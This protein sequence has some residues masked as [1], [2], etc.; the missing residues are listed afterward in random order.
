MKK[1]K[2]G[3]VGASGYSGMELVRL[4]IHHP[5]V[6]LSAVCGLEEIGQRLDEIFPYFHGKSELI[7]I[8]VEDAL[9]QE[10]DVIFFATPDGVAMKYASAFLN[11]G[12]KVIDV[13]G[14][15][16]FQDIAV[17]EKWY[18]RKHTEPELQK[19]AVYGLCELFREEIKKARLIANP[20]CYPTA[21]ILGITPLLKEGIGSHY[22]VDAKTG[23]S[24]AGRKAAQA[25]LFSERNESVTPYKIGYTHKHAPEIE[26]HAGR[27]SGKS[28]TVLFS[29]QVV[30]MTRG[31]L[32]TI[33]V[34]SAKKL[35]INDITNIYTQFYQNN[36]FI[37]IRGNSLP[38]T[39]D[40]YLTNNVHIGFGLDERTDTF[41][42]VSAIDNLIKGASG[43]AVQN[44]NLIFGFPEETALQA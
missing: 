19:E 41:I 2:A 32:E 36:S 33:Y 12:I 1:I 6:E 3:V 26:T 14:D 35:N 30:P 37:H 20:G 34:Q 29:P 40:V 16:R 4:L 24:G 10:L 42:I 27:K 8:S 23:I 9:K 17:Y 5:N 28:C 13:S 31:I 38:S 15:F 44:M 21:A 22:I 39:K 7:F 25:N 11:K 43:Q 18:G